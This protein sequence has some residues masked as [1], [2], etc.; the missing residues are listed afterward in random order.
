M[1]CKEPE[2]TKQGLLKGYFRKALFSN[3][4]VSG[5]WR[6][7]MILE[8]KNVQKEF[9][10]TIALDR[11]YIQLRSGEVNALAG[12]NGAGKSTILKAIAG[13]HRMDAGTI[14]IDGREV[15]IRDTKDAV[16]NGI[17]IVFQESTINPFISISENIFMDRLHTFAKPVVG[18]DWKRLNE[19]AQEILDGMES[20]IDVKTDIRSLNLGQWK[21][22]EVARA[23]SYH[24]QI[25]LLDESTAF[26][27]HTETVSFINSVK[28]LRKD[29]M[30]IGFVSHHMQE[31][32]ELAD[33]ITVM[34]DGKFIVEMLRSEVTQ[35]RLESAMV[36]RSIGDKL[37]PERRQTP[38]EKTVLRVEHLSVENQLSDASFEL[39]EGE[40]LGI[41]GLKQSGGDAIINAIYGAV[42][43]NG[44][45]ITVG[46]ETY[47][48][49]KPVQ[50]LKR[51]IA[52]LP[53]ER[54]LEGLIVNFSIGDN[55][56]MSAG[57][58]KG[59][60]RDRKKEK[61]LVNRYIEQVKIKTD[62]PNNQASS[63]SGGNMQKVV[64]GKC[65]ATDPRI[66]LLNNP[67]RGI[68]ISARQEIYTL[69]RGLANEG[70]SIIMLTEDLLELLGMSD[71]ILITRHNK[72]SK[73]FEENNGLTEEDVISYIV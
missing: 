51:K 11:A 50:S 39:R 35:E 7:E 28:K 18:I 53:G 71:R 45:K 24:P 15:E 52:L 64:I 67:T 23:L 3:Q 1:Y 38:S 57:P 19:S 30:A 22:I 34:R 29:G 4:E 54:T 60:L 2:L 10:P 46:N 59:V 56:V 5:E 42:T 17:S 9:G 6:E 72:I 36:G 33:R 55:I 43:A 49:T 40:I 37:Y 27:N 8:A 68:D 26:L 58:R 25:L 20:G 66:L 44:G 65:L 12:E 47:T 41:G 73:I 14:T 16:A 61:E 31:I 13:V 70:M 63:L 48:A 62:N 32:Y 69:I 21:L